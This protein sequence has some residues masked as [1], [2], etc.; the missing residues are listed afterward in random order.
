[1]KATFSSS[2]WRLGKMELVIDDSEPVTV[3]IVR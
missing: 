3:P 2:L 1:V